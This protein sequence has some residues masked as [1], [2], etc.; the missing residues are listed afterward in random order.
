MNKKMIFSPK[1]ELS[2]ESVDINEHWLRHE[3]LNEFVNDDFDDDIVSKCTIVSINLASKL[4]HSPRKWGSSCSC[5]D[6][7]HVI[8]SN[9]CKQIEIIILIWKFFNRTFKIK[10]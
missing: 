1:R 8:A 5:N 9:K 10:K 2:C 7:R 4:A 3:L 6:K